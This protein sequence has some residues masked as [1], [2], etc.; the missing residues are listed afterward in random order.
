M[1]VETLGEAFRL[2]WRCTVHCH[3]TVDAK[4][5]RHRAA[6]RCDTTE[7]LDVKTLMWTRGERFPLEM[8]ASR[9]RCPKC[10]QE[11]VRVM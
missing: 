6:V 4:R 5:P 8:L 10:G 7:E 1:T 2:G 3:W 11:K 9:L